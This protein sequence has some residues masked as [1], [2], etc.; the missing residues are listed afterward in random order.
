M[1][2]LDGV[3]DRP[4]HSLRDGARSGCYGEATLAVETASSL[5]SLQSQPPSLL[6]NPLRRPAS[7]LLSRNTQRSHPDLSY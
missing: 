5:S 7:S 1:L 3:S 6:L 4:F 2:F